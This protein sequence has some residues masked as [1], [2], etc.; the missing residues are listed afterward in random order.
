M[1]TLNYFRFAENL[2]RSNA[3]IRVVLCTDI[4][5]LRFISYN[6]VLYFLNKADAVVL[7]K[8]CCVSVWISLTL[9]FIEAAQ[10]TEFGFFVC[11][12][13]FFERK[14]TSRYTICR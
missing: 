9:F 14:V 7:I 10:S 2:D 12:L 6:M 13:L 4:S 3:W 11:F 1:L 5:L 8:L